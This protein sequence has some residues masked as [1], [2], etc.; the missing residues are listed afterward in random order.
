MGQINQVWPI[1]AKPR[2]KK[3]GGVSLGQLEQVSV[4]P[5]VGRSLPLLPDV[6]IRV[7]P[8]ANLNIQM[9]VGKS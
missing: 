8:V 4:D 2:L 7:L 6:D 5:D 9:K 3:D 1:E